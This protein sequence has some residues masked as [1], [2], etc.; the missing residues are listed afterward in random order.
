MPAVKHEVRKHNG[1]FQFDP[2]PVYLEFYT[3]YW[4][5]YVGDDAFKIY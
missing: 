5:L 2:R 3:V 1:T 4:R